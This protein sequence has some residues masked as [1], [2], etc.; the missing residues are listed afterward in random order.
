MV[1]E[2]SWTFEFVDPISNISSSCD[3]SYHHGQECMLNATL[4]CIGLSVCV[5]MVQCVCRMLPLELLDC[6]WYY[7]SVINVYIGIDMSRV[8]AECCPLV[9][10][11]VFDILQLFLCHSIVDMLPFKMQVTM[12]HICGT[13][14]YSAKLFK[15]KAGFT[16]AKFQHC[17][18]LCQHVNPG[19]DQVKN[20]VLNVGL[21][22]RPDKVQS[23]SLPK[24]RLMIR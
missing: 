14:I 10:M 17:Y 13:K 22:N 3:I 5:K 20:L 6:Q 15:V 21:N 19:A 1:Y 7:M 18:R 11:M 9:N 16:G 4:G 8:Y 23:T 2:S 24:Y 12:Y